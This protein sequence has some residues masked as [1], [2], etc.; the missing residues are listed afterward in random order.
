VNLTQVHVEDSEFMNITAPRAIFY[1]EKYEI[2]NVTH[3]QMHVESSE[4]T[5][6]R[7]SGSGAIL[8][9]GDY[10]SPGDFN[11]TNVTISE[12]SEICG[13]NLFSSTPR[14]ITL[15]NNSGVSLLSPLSLS[16]S[17]FDTFGNLICEPPESSEIVSVNVTFGEFLYNDTAKF[18]KNGTVEFA[19]VNLPKIPGAKFLGQI[20]W[21][22]QTWD[23]SVTMAPDCGEYHAT[24]V[25]F[26]SL[27][28][29]SPPSPSLLPSLPPPS[30]SLP[31]CRT[32]T[33]FPGLTPFRN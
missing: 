24:I 33:N 28:L 4:F 11:L 25:K 1:L 5:R 10:F 12:I 19:H 2:T 13:K 22:L 23:F 18:G 20:H 8:F 21:H 9:L 6:I 14:N 16:A 29:P 30:L 32:F 15:Y 7:S 26:F 3:V 17:I 31:P 27:S